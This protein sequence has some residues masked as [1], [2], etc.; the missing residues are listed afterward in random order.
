MRDDAMGGATNG[1]C[2]GEAG[3]EKHFRHLLEVLPAGAYTCDATGL[4]TFYNAHA[5]ALWGRAPKLNDPIDR[6][7]GSFRLFS[8]QGEPIAHNQCW[9]ALALQT[10]R[11]YNGEE[12]IVE[13]PD[14]NRVTA[15]AHANPI[16]DATGNLLGAVNV[17]V[18][19]DDRK[20]SEAALT[21]LKDELATQLTDLKRLHAMS[22]QLSKSLETRTILEETLRTATAIEGA[23]FGLIFLR[24]PDQ[25]LWEVGASLGFDADFLRAIQRV[26]LGGGACEACFQ[27][28]RR[29]VIED[30][31]TDARFA[32]YCDLARQAGFRAIHSTPLVTRQGK[33]IGVLSTHFRQPHAPTEREKNLID[34]CARQAVDFLENARLYEQLREGDRRKDEFLATLAHELRNPLAPIS[35]AIQILRLSDDLSP[36]VEMVRDVMERQVTHMVRLIDDLLE[37]SRITRGKLKLRTERAQLVSIIGAAVETSRPIIEA[38]GHQLAITLSPEPMLLEADPLRLAQA[39]ANLLN[40][41]AKYTDDG[42]Q[43]W[44]TA[45]REGGE[46]VISVR[47]TGGGIPAE[48]LSRI[49]ELF[50]QVDRSLHRV[51]GGMGIGLT[52]AKNLVEMH[53]GQIEAHSEGLGRGSEFIVR[54]P[55]SV[56]GR[57]AGPATAPPT[58]RAALPRRRILVVDDTRAAAFTL[59]KLLET[60]EQQVCIVHDAA[61]ALERVQADPPDVVISDIAMPRM[62]G[63]ELAQRLRQLPA[64]RGVALVALTGYGQDSDRQLTSQAGFDFHLVKPVSFH[65]L[66]NLLS[67]LPAPG[68][69][70]ECATSEIRTN[71]R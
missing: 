49:F 51:Q 42:G 71:Q 70:N 15:L 23:D 62:S 66:Y 35:S 58:Q 56:K 36:A 69:V 44:L 29:M 57:T 68:D 22:M 61:T 17:L 14:G 46:A 28:Q 13:R 55:L 21:A 11:E 60:M 45:R 59:G 48:M 33:T 30:V 67:S 6:F 41:A 5:V 18:D 32:P 4:I 8:A 43:I 16:Y 63:Y 7:C 47:D 20:Q 1:G 37:V 2:Q 10:G 54:L 34:L 3:S 65:A 19:V 64:I 27:E 40:N 26:P 50:V 31:A 9:M 24:N 12:I 52:L 38:A 25:H 53:G 39:I